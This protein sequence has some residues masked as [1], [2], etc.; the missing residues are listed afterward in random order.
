MTICPT[1]SSPLILEQNSYISTKRPRNVFAYLQSI[2]SVVYTCGSDQLKRI[3]VL[4]S[5]KVP[6]KMS[7]G[8][9][10]VKLQL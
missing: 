9:S 1:I 5:L 4:E 10:H 3:V 7:F 6:L 8:R 2:N